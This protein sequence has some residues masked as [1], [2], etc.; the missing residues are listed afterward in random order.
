[1]VLTLGTNDLCTFLQEWP[2]KSTVCHG[3][4]LFTTAKQYEKCVSQKYKLSEDGNDAILWIR[5][6]YRAF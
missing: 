3:E 4:I 6:T 2:V 5:S 1:M